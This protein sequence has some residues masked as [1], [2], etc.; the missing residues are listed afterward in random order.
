MAVKAQAIKFQKTDKAQI[1]GKIGHSRTGA[2]TAQ[3]KCYHGSI[4]GHNRR[5]K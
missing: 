4:Q 2:C 5:K 1:R 3:G